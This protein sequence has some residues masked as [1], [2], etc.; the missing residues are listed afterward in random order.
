MSTLIYNAKIYLERER[1]AQ[2]MLINDQG[3]IE[4]VG[5]NE[6]IKA[7]AG[8]ATCYDAAGRT[9]VPGFNDSHQHLFNT[10][11]A[12]A[13]VHLQGVTSIDGNISKTMNCNLAKSFSVWDGTRTISPMST[14]C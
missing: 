7:L 5:T 13:S 1:F 2:A 11:I 8:D 3:R 9:I 12:L 10:G 4:A 6:E 14:V